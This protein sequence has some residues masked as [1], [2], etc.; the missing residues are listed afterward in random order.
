MIVGL[1]DPTAFDY[2]SATPRPQSQDVD[3]SRAQTP[4]HFYGSRAD[5]NRNKS[6][7]SSRTAASLRENRPVID[8]RPMRMR[9]HH[10]LPDNPLFVPSSKKGGFW[11]RFFT[12]PENPLYG[13]AR[14]KRHRLPESPFSRSASVRSRR[15]VVAPSEGGAPSRRYSTTSTVRRR[16]SR[17]PDSPW[18]PTVPSH[19]STKSRA[20]TIKPIPENQVAE[21][22]Y[23][24]AR[25][26]SIMGRTLSQRRKS[27]VSQ[28]KSGSAPGT[29]IKEPLLGEEAV[30]GVADGNAVERR[31]L[32]ANGDAVERR[33]IARSDNQ[34]GRVATA[35][36]P[37]EHGRI[38]PVEDTHIEDHRPHSVIQEFEPYPEKTAA[39]NTN[40]FED[41]RPHS[42]MEAYEHDPRPMSTA[43]N[44]SR[45]AS[46][47]KTTFKPASRAPSRPGL[48]DG[49][50][51]P[52]YSYSRDGTRTP[53]LA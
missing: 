16:N 37:D 18:T 51:Q 46:I 47:L 21:D 9:R 8:N 41:E 24:S 27:L 30:N 7:R 33:S 42:V 6:V 12:L 43:S 35:T 29:S 10:T 32:A 39:A 15:S 49:E 5:V 23:P 11:S 44:R 53:I 3:A 52:T 36:E 31:S 26:S 20:S 1:A 40:G 50:L 2:Q 38:D 14:Q 25:R 28:S 19:R 45:P 17:L 4:A 48:V 22:E 13:P 34:L